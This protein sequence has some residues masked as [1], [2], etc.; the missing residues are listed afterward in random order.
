MLTL[1][2]RPLPKVTLTQALLEQ[3]QILN[4]IRARISAK[5]KLGNI[6]NYRRPTGVSDPLV[7][8]QRRGRELK[9][10]RAR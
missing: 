7:H 5:P 6:I 3:F 2:L 1:K 9:I 8:Q 4:G 10:H